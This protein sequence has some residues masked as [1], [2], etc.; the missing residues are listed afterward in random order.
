MASPMPSNTRVLILALV[1]VAVAVGPGVAAAQERTGGS[2]VVGPDETV[3]GDLE[4][5]GGSVVVEGRVTGDLDASAGS[6]R[7][8]GTVDGDVSA[9]AGSVD[10]GPDARIGGDLEATGGSVSI[11]GAV[12]G[13]VEAA[14]ETITLASSAEVGGDLTYAG[15]LVR[16]DGATVGGTVSQ[17]DVGPTAFDSDVPA[18][19]DWAFSAY[20]LLVNALLGAVL[21]FAF[22]GFSS[23]VAARAT[24]TPLRSGGVGLL[25]LVG[26]P[27]ALVLSMVTI[28]GIPLALAGLLLYGLLVWVGAVYGRYAVGTWLL[29]LVGVDN[30]WVAL[31]AGLLV[32]A[33]LKLVPYLGGF[34]EL[35]VVLLG[36]GA[37]SLSLTE[38]YRR[39]RQVEPETAPAADEG[40]VPT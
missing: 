22:P 9:A 17:G 15:D 36:L 40:G 18:A 33:G 21:L 26:I 5:V 25:A 39:G 10:V 7:I 27:V 4:A 19:P 34:V 14:A 3:D 6:V 16:E 23:G 29:S 2:V 32:V 30:R 31:L 8:E 1:V 11:A 38:R 24:D 13:N 37:L 20:G 28:V 12:D 35:V